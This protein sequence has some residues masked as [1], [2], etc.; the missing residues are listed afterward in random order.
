M[1]G[2]HGFI[3]V[4]SSRLSVEVTKNESA[5]LVSSNCSSLED[6]GANVHCTY[7]PLETSQIGAR[8]AEA[9]HAGKCHHQ[10]GG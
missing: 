1:H 4:L 2:T 3:V 9:A 5:E 10:V 6:L 8:E 7:S